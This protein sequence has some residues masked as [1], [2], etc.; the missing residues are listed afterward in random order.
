M[1]LVADAE[2]L[3]RGAGALLEGF[4]GKLRRAD[5][6]RKGGRR[7]LV[8]EADLASQA[9]LLARIPS[10][11]DVLSEE[12]AARSTGAARTWVI[13]PLDG[14]INFLHG[15]PN[16]CV[17]IGVVENGALTAAAVV[18]P[19]L[20]QVYTAA[21]GEGAFC[22]GERIRVSGTDDIGDAILATGLAYRRNE[23]PDHNLDNITT[24]GFASADLRRMG[25]AAID[26]CY[27]ASGR[28]DGFWELHLNA[29]DVAAGILI[30]REAG[31]KVT[32][33]RG[34]ERLEDLLSGR[35]VVASNRAVHDQIRSRL[36]PL[37]G[38]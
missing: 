12:G 15:L 31:G 30:V 3:G 37:R 17:S 13:D 11:D 34:S 22:N 19:E 35:H 1:S 4:F 18:A 29:W 2:R 14:T 38:L 5:A 27:V 32:D 8:S 36:A 16:W 26:L 33:F 23:L 10:A 28:I 25:A 6:T 7:D 9:Y 24:L 20:R 21:A